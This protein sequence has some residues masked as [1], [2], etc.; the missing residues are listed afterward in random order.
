VSRQIVPVLLSTAYGQ[1]EL[2]DTL[3]TGNYFIRVYTPTMFVQDSISY[4]SQNIFVFGKKNRKSETVLSI[5]K[6]LRLEF[7]PESGHFISGLINTVAFKATNEYGL[8]AQVSGKIRNENGEVI[9]SFNTY[10]D[11]MG[12]FDM[13]PQANDK[14]FAVINEDSTAGK[15]YLPGQTEQGVVFKIISTGKKKYFELLQQA[16]DPSL[17]AAFM[18]GQMQ[19]HVVFRQEFAAGKTEASGM[20][21]V[22][23]LNSGIMQ[24]TVFN[25]D[26]IPLAERLTFV[27]NGEYILPAELVADTIDFSAKGK[28]NFHV[29]LKDT[30]LGFFSISVTDPEYDLYSTRRQNILSSLLLTSDLKGYIHNPAYYFSEKSDSVYNSLD[31]VMMINGWRRFKWQKLS[32]NSL[33]VRSSKDPGFITIDGRINIKET[34]KPFANRSLIIFVYCPDSSRIIRMASTDAHGYFKVD[35]L[36]FFDRSRIVFKDIRGKKSDLLEVN[37]SGDSL[38]KNFLF[39]LPDKQSF[40]GTIIQHEDKLAKW[41]DDY[42]AFVK[43]KGLLLSGI[44]VKTRKK[45]P[46]EEL[47]EK[48][49][50]GLFNGFSAHT[51]DLVNTTDVITQENIFEYLA[52]RVPGLDVR[53]D[54][55]D[56]NIYYRQGIASASA[57]GLIPMTLY[58]DEYETDASFIS[59]VPAGDVALVKVF[60]SFVGAFGNGAGGAL[61]IYTK[62]GSDIYN[63]PNITDMVKYQGYSVIKEFYA[64]NYSVDTVAIK[65][66]DNRITILWSPQ[67]IVSSINGSIPFTFYNSDRT[68]Q[69]KVVVEGMTIDGKLI[70]IEKTFRQKP[71]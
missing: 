22:S 37:L 36:L 44:T 49:T 33:P 43:A 11:G 35:S 53:R 1:F 39:P 40:Y 52:Y 32:D 68:K 51:Y 57:M 42:D 38:T 9:T 69:F 47:E 58:L 60:S 45:N 64:P 29:S 56:Y 13:T 17:K 34:R 5:P 61:A 26:N 55:L 59:S 16:N 30:V 65:K 63:S 62:K 27:D 19:H 7:F 14:Y 48:Y 3:R 66:Q 24:V 18:I 25:K 2:P 41:E 4:G 21:D 23:H 46:V 31:L 20:I 8:P 50:S 15:Y 28:N 71:F 70:M 67:I 54:G 12:M 10:H 6:A